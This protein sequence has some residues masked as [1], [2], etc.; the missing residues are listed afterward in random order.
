MIEWSDELSVGVAGIDEQHRAF[1][2]LVERFAALSRDNPCAEQLRGILADV[3]DYAVVHFMEEERLMREA[4]Y[5]RLAEHAVK[6]HAAASR[7]QAL[8]A[9]DTGRIERYRF[10]ATFLKRWLLSHILGED[11]AFG[12]WLAAN[13]GAAGLDAREVA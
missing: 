3:M 13:R 2:G 7:I 12:R 1:V 11:K 8:L 5:P 4:G 10:L 9:K 6:H